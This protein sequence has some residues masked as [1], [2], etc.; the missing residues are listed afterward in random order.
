MRVINI[1]LNSQD[2]YKQQRFYNYDKFL[3]THD[4]KVLNITNKC[5]KEN[6][7]SIIAKENIIK[8]FSFNKYD[9][10]AIK[11]LQNIICK[12]QADIIIAHDKKAL[13]LSKYANKL[14]NNSIPIIGVCS[15][16][17]I[18]PFIGLD[19]LIIPLDILRKNLLEQGQT[20]RT[21]YYIPDTIYRDINITLVNNFHKTPIIGLIGNL[22]TNKSLHK[23]IESLTILKNESIAYKVK[24]VQTGKL[25]KTLEDLVISANLQKKVSFVENINKKKHFFNKIDI[26]YFFS[27]TEYYTST[28]LQ[29]ISFK[30]PIITAKNYASGEIIKHKDNGLIF[31]NHDPKVIAEALKELMQNQE[32]AK[33]YSNNAYTQLESRL[34]PDRVSEKLVNCLNEIW[35]R[36]KEKQR[37]SDKKLV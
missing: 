30:K 34:N 6:D 7:H 5:N 17:I 12:Y 37:Y 24:I 18:S 15:D 25:Q 11:K 19:S 28:L 31:S 2:Y 8:L 20:P 3:K 29:A 21:I 4:I 14:F 16:K 22:Q 33:I 36:N 32:L 9:I 27:D 23:L 1:L 13:S 35:L 10:I 26:C